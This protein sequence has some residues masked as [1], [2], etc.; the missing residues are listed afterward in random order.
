MIWAPGSSGVLDRKLPGA[1]PH[2]ERRAHAL[3]SIDVHCHCLPGLDDGPAT[4]EESIS[5]CRLLVTD[6]IGTVIATPHQLGLYDGRNASDAIRAGCAALEAE[7]SHRNI[8]LQV[9]P[10]ADVR[11]D[12]RLAGML[13]RDEVLT[14]ADRRVHL[15][16]E[17]PHETLIDP[18]PLLRLLARKK[19]Q[20]IITH[21]ERHEQL[22]KRL[23]SI[24]AW[25]G[26]GAIC[27]V[28]AGSLLGDFG[29]SAQSA[30]WRLLEAGA[31][32][33]IATDAHD[34]RRRPPRMS[35]AF[36]EIERRLG[37]VIARRVCVDN[38]LS[39]SQGRRCPN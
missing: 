33:L 14:L 37:S 18:R 6:G 26:E 35:R 15:L 11:I 8:P 28:T 36:A 3:A 25:I 21:P 27:Q 31:A 38:P 12:E 20:P 9:L 23:E 5:L 29:Q 10:G 2:P 16:L 1:G 39:V 17:L 22:R 30:G 32:H 34:V 7:L 24:S 13:D 4:L 19:L